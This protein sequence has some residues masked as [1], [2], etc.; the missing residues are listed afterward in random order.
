LDKLFAMAM[1][2]EHPGID[3]EGIDTM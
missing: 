2:L 3:R 1:S